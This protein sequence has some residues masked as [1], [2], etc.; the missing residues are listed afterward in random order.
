MKNSDDFQVVPLPRSRRAIQDMLR[1]GKRKHMV[2]GLL[3][4]DVTTPRQ[5]INGHL[6]ATGEAVLH[7]LYHRLP[8]TDRC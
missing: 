5:Q 3:E 7:R 1:E 8:W 4:L 6:A 2:H